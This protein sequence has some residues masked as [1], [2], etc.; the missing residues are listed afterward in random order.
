MA[1]TPTTTSAT[2]NSLHPCRGRPHPSRRGSVASFRQDPD[3]P[4]LDFWR[5]ARPFGPTLSELAGIALCFVGATLRFWATRVSAQ[6]FPSR[7]R[8]PYALVRNPLYLGTYL[9]A[10]GTAWAMRLVALGRVH[11]PLCRDL[12][13]ISFWTRDEAEAHIRSPYLTYCER[14]P[15]F[16]LVLAANSEALA[17]VNPEPRTIDSLG[18]WRKEQSLRKL[19]EPFVLLIGFVAAVAF[20]LAE[21]QLSSLHTWPSSARR[22]SRDSGEKGRIAFVGPSHGTQICWMRNPYIIASRLVGS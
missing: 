9:M 16:F 19:T 10:I 2:S 18:P 20:G 11:G 13:I 22:S 7:R 3:H 17:Q 5:P 14:V 21:I 8:G 15:R 6:G 4:G 12:F 1:S